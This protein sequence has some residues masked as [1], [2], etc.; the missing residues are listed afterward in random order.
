MHTYAPM[1]FVVHTY[2]PMT[3]LTHTYVLRTIVVMHIRVP[4]T[5]V[6]STKKIVAQEKKTS[7]SFEMTG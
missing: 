3:L 6:G 4:V 1:T 5:L 7:C 2:A